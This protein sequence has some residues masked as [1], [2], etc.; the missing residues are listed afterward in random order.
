MPPAC[1][2]MGELEVA[3]IGSPAHLLEADPEL[4]LSVVT[5]QA[6]APL[7]APRPLDSNKGSFGHVLMVAGSPGKSGAAAM[8]GVAA[9]RAGAGLVTVASS[10]PVLGAVSAYAP[11]LM[12]EALPQGAGE[13]VQLAAKRSLT[14]IGPG[15]GTSSEA[16]EMVVRLWSEAAHPMVVD[17]DALNCLAAGAWPEK[18][19]GPRVLTPHPGEM[20]RLVGMPVSAVQSDRIGCARALAQQRKV[21]VVL[22]GERTL[23]AF[24]DGRVWIN[25][26][27]SPSMAKGGTGDVLTGMIAGLMAQFPDDHD[28]AVAGAVYLHGLAGQ[29][30]ARDRAEQTILATDLLDYLPEGIRAIRNVSHGE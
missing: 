15:I 18:A 28:R 5:P 23:I 6:I 2:F 3:A 12:T 21:T 13:V 4:R 9:L 30:A 22:K 14:A 8:A 16:R 1:G 10:G 17:A 19:A 25:P 29:L 27:G 24:A 7:F 20:S 26:T 11:E